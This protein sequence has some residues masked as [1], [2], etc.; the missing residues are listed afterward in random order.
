MGRRALRKSEKKKYQ[1][2]HTEALA[3]IQTM[4]R[5]KTTKM[6]GDA[7]LSPDGGLWEHDR[8][9]NSGRKVTM[10]QIWPHRRQAPEGEDTDAIPM[11]SI[12]TDSCLSF[13][14]ARVVCAGSLCPTLP[15]V[16]YISL[17]QVAHGNTGPIYEGQLW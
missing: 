14:C 7:S 6:Q 1:R 2:K 12:P 15:C 13:L 11:I 16:F 17:S 9:R 5:Q 10:S 3:S 4:G 8:C